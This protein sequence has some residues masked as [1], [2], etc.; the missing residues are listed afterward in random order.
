MDQ[1]FII[2]SVDMPEEIAN[3]AIQTAF[4][5]KE[6]F[7]NH[8]Q[9]AAYIKRQFDSEFQPAW[10]CIVGRGFGSFVT[11]DTGNLVYFFLEEF[12]IL[13]WKSG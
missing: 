5:A 6:K 8:N 7:T 2:K 10:H 12:A 9:I 11:H 3:K 1:R 4:D 13:L